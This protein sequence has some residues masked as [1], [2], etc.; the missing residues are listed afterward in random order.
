[1]VWS[2]MLSSST[3]WNLPPNSMWEALRSWLLRGLCWHRGGLWENEA[4]QSCTDLIH[5]SHP[6]LG[7][8]LH[9]MEGISKPHSGKLLPHSLVIGSRYSKSPSYPYRSFSLIL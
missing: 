7:G 2:E 3:V 9:R 1:M 6:G 8:F 4:V 5:V